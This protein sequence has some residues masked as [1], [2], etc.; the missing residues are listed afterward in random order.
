MTLPDAFA[1]RIEDLPARD[2]LQHLDST[3]A[4]PLPIA[5]AHRVYRGQNMDHPLQPKLVRTVTTDPA[6]SG[7]RSSDLLVALSLREAATLI[8]FAEYCDQCGYE[9]HGSERLIGKTPTELVSSN[10]RSA[11]DG[12]L[13]EWPPDWLLPLLAVAQHYGVATRLLDL[14]TDPLTALYFALARRS[15]DPGTRVGNAVVWV[16]DR[17]RLS[18]QDGHAKIITVPSVGNPHL[19][20]Q[21]G[22]F[23]ADR[24][25]NSRIN[26]S[27][28]LPYFAARSSLPDEPPAA[29]KVVIPRD[30]EG[31]L[32]EAL[33]LRGYTAVRM[34]PSLNTAGAE[35]EA[36]G[37]RS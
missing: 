1:M 27:L 15:V 14:T 13:N 28:P 12:A 6:F 24:G 36:F 3:H 17:S 29:V 2:I 9:I 19:R 33:V 4:L 34:Y 37:N 10:S 5:P 18:A 23:L 30:A 31:R 11:Q 26:N 21:A 25:L 32:A 20:A 16:F 7:L 35:A 8:R 22:I